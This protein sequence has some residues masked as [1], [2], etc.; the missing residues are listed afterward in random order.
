MV[1]NR[2]KKEKLFLGFSHNAVKTI[3]TTIL[4]NMVKKVKKRKMASITD[5]IRASRS[6]TN[7]AIIVAQ[8]LSAN[9]NS[10]VVFLT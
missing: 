3:A 6:K 10:F 1:L 9:Q 4:V 7:C 8:Q 5:V 2:V